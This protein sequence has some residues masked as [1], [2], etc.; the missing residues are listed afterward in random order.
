[1]EALDPFKI[2][3]SLF[4]ED[5]ASMD[6]K[7]AYLNIPLF[8][9]CQ[10]FLHFPVG[11]HNH[12][13][14]VFP[15]GM[16]TAL[17]VFTKWFGLA[18][19][20]HQG[21]DVVDYLNNLQSSLISQ[22]IMQTWIHHLR[23]LLALSHQLEYL[24]WT[25]YTTLSRFSCNRINYCSSIRLLHASMRVLGMMVASRH[26]PVFYARLLQFNILDAWDK[27]TWW[28]FSWCS[29]FL[30]CL[31]HQGNAFPPKAVVV[32]T[33]SSLL[34]WEGVLNALSV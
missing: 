12:Q 26:C 19:L 2:F 6:I 4:P 7:D 21:M 32:M 20:S 30:N 10:W 24:G 13:C 23:K 11:A 25:L 14:V 22:R 15:L 34:G 29:G 8:P 17:W 5:L 3:V 31:C 1:M 28:I 9:P 27:Q 16:T 33:D 18:L